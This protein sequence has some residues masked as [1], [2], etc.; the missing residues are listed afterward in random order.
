MNTQRWALYFSPP[1]ELGQLGQQ[2][3]SD[4]FVPAAPWTAA[5]RRYG[6]HATLK[7]PFRLSPGYTLSDLRAAIAVW[8]G[9][10]RPFSVRLSVQWLG[11]FPALRPVAEADN[12]ALAG[13]AASAVAQLDPFRAELSAAEEQRR[14]KAPLTA[15]E[16][17]LLARWG[18]PYVFE[19]FRFHCTLTEPLPPEIARDLFALAEQHFNRVLSEPVLIDHVVLVEEPEPNANF[20]MVER[21]RLGASPPGAEEPPCSMESVA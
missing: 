11:G 2:W 1:D 9:L 13:L 4:K 19:A 8:T 15:R 20:M 21:F 5:P 10:Q 3:L 16:R 12:A 6:F 14:L 17:E 18:Y 7:A